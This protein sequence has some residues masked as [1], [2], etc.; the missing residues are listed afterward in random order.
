[1]MRTVF[2]DQWVTAVAHPNIALIK[3]WGKRDEQLILPTTDS[4]SMTLDIYPTTTRV[5]VCAEAGADAVHIDDAPAIG[6]AY[7]RVTRFLDLVRELSGRTE[8]ASVNTRN[9]VPAAAGLASSAAG[10]AALATASA[11]A[12][13][14][15]LDSMA[16]SRLARRGSGSASRSIFGGFAVWR[17]GTGHS[18]VESYAE[19]IDRGGLDPA[20]V[21]AVVDPGPKTM[22]SRD[23]MRHTVQTS[24]LYWSWVASSRVDIA[25]MRVCIERGDL[26]GTGEIAEHNALGMHATMLAARPAVRYLSAASLTVIDTVAELRRADIA[27]YVTVDAGPNVKVL[28]DCASAGAVAEALRSLDCVR[29]VV[30]ARPGPGARLLS[31]SLQ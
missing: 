14:L 13:G 22:S 7:G 19:P 18:D 21:V 5:R 12:Y 17:A 4:L 15:Q 25:D 3:Y 23:A 16:L 27:A 1:M 20:L 6:E 31:R 24:P 30:T 26:C 11:A 10:F 29:K 28:C 2:E 9:T 8:Y